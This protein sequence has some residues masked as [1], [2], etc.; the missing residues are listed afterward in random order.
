MVVVYKENNL[1][2]GEQVNCKGIKQKK[3]RKVTREA[4]VDSE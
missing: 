4:A 2:V 1:I 3:R